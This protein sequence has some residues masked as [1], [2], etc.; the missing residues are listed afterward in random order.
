MI[1]PVTLKELNI[2]TL[3]DTFSWLGDLE[4]TQLTEV[5]EELNPALANNFMFV[6]LPPKNEVL[7]GQLV[8]G[9][10]GGWSV[11]RSVADFL[12]GT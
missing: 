9:R 4:V 3:I 6:Y 10:A 2:L 1:R 12:S 5:Q 11:G 7:G 8:V